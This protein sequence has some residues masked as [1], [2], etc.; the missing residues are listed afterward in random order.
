MISSSVVVQ[1]AGVLLEGL[2]VAVLAAVAAAV[3]SSL[4]FNTLCDDE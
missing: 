3:D 1:P 2:A 4:I